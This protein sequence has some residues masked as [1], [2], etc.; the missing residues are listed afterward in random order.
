MFKLST[1]VENVDIK[2]IN[3]S[4]AQNQCLQC[5]TAPLTHVE[6]SDIF[7]TKIKTRT[8]IIGRRFQ[9]TKLELQ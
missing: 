4:L 1:A 6:I 3:A 7:V 2:V 9:K 5:V 8:R